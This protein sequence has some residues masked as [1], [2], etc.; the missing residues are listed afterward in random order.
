MRFDNDGSDK[1]RGMSYEG[2]NKFPRRA[3]FKTQDIICKN[4]KPFNGGLGDSL[5][6]IQAN[7]SAELGIKTLLYA[8][9]T[10]KDDVYAPRHTA[11][12]QDNRHA[13]SAGSHLPT[14]SNN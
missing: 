4:H 6:T 3:E 2:E 9:H 10:Q 13:T 7:T 14:T 11:I 12:A 5:I 1:Y 8:H